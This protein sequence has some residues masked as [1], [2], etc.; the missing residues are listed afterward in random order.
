[1]A[2]ASCCLAPATD[3]RDRRGRARGRWFR[4][5][6]AAVVLA[7]AG[8]SGAV[9]AANFG[10]VTAELAVL[11]DGPS[12]KSR[13]LFLVP[14]GAPLQIL[15]SLPDWVKVRDSVGDVLW[16][17]RTDLGRA[18]HV[19]ISAETAAIHREP[20]EAAPV[21]FRGARGLLLQVTGG[22]SAGWLPVEQGGTRGFVRVGEV[23]GL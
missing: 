15:S 1:M 19:L 5:M 8:A 3:R 17:Q 11:F 4:Q 12:L 14:R 6:A 10:G 22:Q 20:R 9:S 18:T 7:T 13:K 21:V 16:I 2:R 23:W